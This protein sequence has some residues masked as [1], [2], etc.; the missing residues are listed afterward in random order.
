MTVA[1]NTLRSQEPPDQRDHVALKA[2][3]VAGGSAGGIALIMK[4]ADA[5]S[6]RTVQLAIIVFGVVLVVAILAMRRR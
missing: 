6:E 5:S 4:V 2:L 1:R 3:G